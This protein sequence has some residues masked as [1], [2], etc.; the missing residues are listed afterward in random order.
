MLAM[1]LRHRA[2]QS[3]DPNTENNSLFT[4]LLKDKSKTEMLHQ[5]LSLP[6]TTNLVNITI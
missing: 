2:H 6:C 5:Q 3:T 1:N 4:V